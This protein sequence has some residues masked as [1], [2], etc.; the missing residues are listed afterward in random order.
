[1]SVSL[2][3]CVTAVPVCSLDRALVTHSAWSLAS[4]DSSSDID[5]TLCV[6]VLFVAFEDW[7]LVV[8][9]PSAIGGVTPPLPFQARGTSIISPNL[10]SP[11]SANTVKLISGAYASPFVNDTST[12]P[13]ILAFGN[14]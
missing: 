11:S 5:P 7:S 13:E 4:T 3:S 10:D 1:M 14:T 6:T 8:L 2:S 12:V 9:S